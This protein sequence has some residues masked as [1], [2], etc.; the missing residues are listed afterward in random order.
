[1]F[2]D[3]SVT[4]AEPG[5]IE[6]ISAFWITYTA[7]RT[8]F[9]TRSAEAEI[10]LLSCRRSRKLE[11]M[12]RIVDPVDWTLLTDKYPNADMFMTASSTDRQDKV[13]L[14]MDVEYGL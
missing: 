3:V 1:M 2:G 7:F 12:P 14:A 13:P 5:S 8:D 6:D 10:G 4:G 11:E 9:M